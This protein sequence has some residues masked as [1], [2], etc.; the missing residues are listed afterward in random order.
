MRYVGLTA[1][2]MIAPPLA[3]LGDTNPRLMASAALLAG[4]LFLPLAYAVAAPPDDTAGAPRAEVDVSRQWQRHLI[5]SN[6]R[7]Y[8]MFGHGVAD[9]NGDGR[10]D[11]L[12]CSSVRRDHQPSDGIYWY[13][14]PRNPRSGRWRRK[15]LS[16]PDHPIYW[17][18]ALVAGDVDNDGDLDVVA[19]SFDRSNVY[20]CL[21]PLK[22]GG[23]I[24]QPWQ[25]LII[26][27]ANANRRD[28]ERVELTD[29]DGD[30]FKDVVF[31]RG[32]RPRS[33]FVLFN[34][35]GDPAQ[36]WIKK[37]IGKIAGS[38]AHDIY[39]ADIDRDGD[40][41]I[42]N[43]SGDSSPRGTGKVYWYEHPNGNPRRGTWTRRAVTTDNA[44][45]GGLN[46]ADLNGDGWVDLVASHAHDR[47]IY[48]FENPKGNY[49]KDWP[50]H[51]IG[52]L[53]YPHVNTW[54]DVDGDGVDELWVPDSSFSGYG[55]RKGG[56]AYFKRDT[57]ATRP[58]VLHRVAGA[59]EVGRPPV[60]IDV[61]GDGDLDIICGADH[62]RSPNPAKRASIVWW[63]NK[64]SPTPVI[65]SR[66]E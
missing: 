7:L 66:G 14:I 62:G 5:E 18:M 35:A 20:L 60:A 39:T 51:G 33:V 65:R 24:D 55:S 6:V 10:L 40:L 15:R 13:E 58:W 61:D 64:T 3:A 30:G 46:K 57:D 54:I 25:T 23:D 12:F 37:E 28:G 56:L 17:S 48:W 38:D 52:S 63:E 53:N 21:N 34:P 9:L 36:P 4:V 11:Y 59:P 19:L 26:L 2:T 50:R 45:W 32:D 41:D 44:C 27:R 42:V 16:H 22:Q 49:G 8:A 29:L 43:A 1:Q 31:P 47:N